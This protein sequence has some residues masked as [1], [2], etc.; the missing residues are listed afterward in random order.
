MM[1]KNILFRAII[2]SSS[3]LVI[4]ACGGGGSSD[5]NEASSGNSSNGK[6]DLTE[7]IFH[8]NLDLVGEI[9]SYPVK[10][11]SK[12]DGTEQ[13]AGIELGEIYEKISEDT[14]T[15][16]ESGSSVPE[17]TFLINESTILETVH[18][19]NNQSRDL[20]RFVDVGTKY[21]DADATTALAEQ[22]AICTVMEHLDTFDLS[23]ATD[24]YNL[25]SGVYEDVL[26]VHCITSFVI[27]GNLA[28]HT[29]LHHY[30]A[31]DIGPIFN[32]GTV[33]ILG[34]A[35]IIPQL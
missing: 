22:N 31:K 6:Y 20:Q 1:K 7:Y 8:R 35:Y 3:M 32:E 23:T 12:T 27:D 17:N 33:L 15:F 28:P 24:N 5:N 2:L 9:Y 13:Y 16:R 18:A 21:M 4:S 29:D 10:L 34:D 30:F 26:H 19:L 11:Y 14:V 25:A